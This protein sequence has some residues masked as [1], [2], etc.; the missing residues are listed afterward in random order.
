[1]QLLFAEEEEG[2]RAARATQQEGTLEQ[3]QAALSL[4]AACNTRC[5]N[6]IQ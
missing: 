5:H 1:V 4:A 6:S 3:K 2:E